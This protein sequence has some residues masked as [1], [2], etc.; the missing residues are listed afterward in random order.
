MSKYYLLGF[1]LLFI[2][3]SE[4]INIPKPPTYLRLN[5]P[6]HQYHKFI[7]SNCKYSFDA[8]TIF[9][10]K[11]VYQEKNKTCH[12]DIHLDKL[13][14][15]MHFSYIEMEKPLS[16]Y[17][18][19][20]INKVDEHKIKANAIEDTSF[21]FPNK[22]VFGTFFEIQGDVASPFQFYLTDST[23]RFISAVVYFN[24]RPNYDSLIPT[25]QYL[26][27]DLFQMINSFQWKK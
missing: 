3:C 21:I 19:Y 20:A 7:E 13:N 8:P 15:I 11:D 18:N 10:I 25:L 23:D 22:R 6:E 12:K 4:E 16:E 26:K 24:S 27:T 5:L 1:L 14:G 9:K 2:S 17:V